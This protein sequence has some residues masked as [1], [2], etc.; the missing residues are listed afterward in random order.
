M[1]PVIRSPFRPWALR[2]YWLVGCVI[3]PACASASFSVQVPEDLLGA[4]T[5]AVRRGRHL[6][7]TGHR[8]LTFG[9]FQAHDIRRSSRQSREEPFLR[10]VRVRVSERYSFALREANEEL[11]TAACETEVEARAGAI[12][13]VEISWVSHTR[14]ACT[15][16]SVADTAV[17]WALV[18]QSAGEAPLTGLLE[19]EGARLQLLGTDATAQGPRLPFETTGYYIR[20]SAG[21]WAA[22]DVLSSGAV[23]LIPTLTPYQRVLCAGVAAAL[24]LFDNL[25][26]AAS[27]LLERTQ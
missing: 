15:L 7:R 22:I 18:A 8:S 3:V 6:F 4:S 24:L 23:L 2:R 26:A 20:G 25:R 12:G 21:P 19:R 16:T 10:P 17:T 1:Q 5:F 13:R 11:W 27:T 9:S 14:L